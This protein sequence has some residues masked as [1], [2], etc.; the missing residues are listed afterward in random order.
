[1]IIEDA[2]RP[3]TCIDADATFLVTASE[4]GMVRLY[5]HRPAADGQAPSSPTELVHI[6]RREAL[7]IRGVALECSS[8]QGSRSTPRVAICSDELIVRVVNAVDTRSIT[9]LSGHSRGVRAASWSPAVSLLLTCGCDGSIRAWDMSSTEPSCIKVMDA[10]LPMLRPESEFTSLACWHPSGEF[11]AVPSKTQEIMLV[12]AP[13]SLEGS[14][15]AD[16]WTTLD[17]LGS[18]NAATSASHRLPRGLVSALAFSPNG[19][20]LAVATEDSQVTIWA[21]DSRKIVRTQQGEGIV[22]GLSWHPSADVLAWTDMQGQLVRWDQPIGATLPSPS[23]EVTFARVAPAAAT[24]PSAAEEADTFD[25]LFDDTGIDEGEAEDVGRRVRD[26]PSVLRPLSRRSRAGRS[27][28]ASQ[29]LLPTQ[30]AFQPGSTPMFAQRRFLAMSPIGTLTAIDQDTHQT[31]SFESYDTTQR[32]NFRFTD[33]YGYKMAALAPQGVLFACDAEARSP[34]SVFFRPFDDLAGILS[35]WSLSLPQGETATA[36]ALGGVANM[37]SYADVHVPNSSLVDESKTTAA[38]AVVATS[39]GYLRFLGPSGMQRYVWALGLP[40]V[41]MAASQHFVLV[42]YHEATVTAA[43]PALGYLLIDLTELATMQRGVLPI[44]ADATLTWAGFNELSYPAVYDSAGTLFVLDRAWRPGQG[45]WVPVLDTVA[46]LTPAKP[47]DASGLGAEDLEAAP[48]PRVR[49]WPLGVTATHL[50]GLL[51]P[52]SQ[53]FPRADGPRPLVQELELSL[54][55]VQRES[56]AVQFEEV[57]LRRSLLSGMVRDARAATGMDSLGAASL[58]AEQSDPAA[59]DMDADKALLQLIQLACKADRYARAL[60]AARALHSEPTL[61]AALQITSFFH[62]PSLGDRLE[63]VRAPLA[64]RRELEREVT[65]RACGTEAL[66]RNLATVRVPQPQAAEPAARADPARSEL[67]RE[68]FEAR[69]PPPVA[70]RSALAQEGQM[71]AAAPAPSTQSDMWSDL[72]ELAPVPRPSATQEPSETPTPA[73]PPEPAAPVAPPVRANPFARTHSAARE[74]S[75]HKSSS[76]FDRADGSKRKHED[77]SAGNERGKRTSSAQRQSTL[78]FSRNAE[79]EGL[80][81][82]EETPAEE[83]PPATDETGE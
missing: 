39:R 74:R 48:A 54:C 13:L 64:V 14:A 4:D 10:V 20:Y 41:T 81:P 50:L 77:S 36:V 68:G 45:C 19:R 56:N 26:E 51:L 53:A 29:D 32:R 15:S 57:A 78:G 76:F 16:A 18:A 44:V 65:E 72:G 5:R 75:L 2:T 9:L 8:A 46:A 1:M 80:E 71:S 24:A 38:S 31:V 69:R 62:L 11:F 33:H 21:T 83:L 63:G 66:L 34:S 55:L 6:V 3:M 52:P 79:S 42:V 40:V 22:T 49:C 25:D 61:D 23:E 43:H 70:S 37:G 47:A 7:P 67:L 59:L 30:R 60:D 28:A 17:V 35:E 58:T 73:G 27:A 82:S 12:K